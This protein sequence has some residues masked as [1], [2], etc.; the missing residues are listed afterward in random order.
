MKKLKLIMVAFALLLGVSNASAGTDVTASY[1]GDVTW[2]VNG[3]GWHGS[4]SNN[5]KESNGIG[6]YNSQTISGSHAFANPSG[7]NPGESWSPNFGTAGIMMGRTMV[8]PE[9]NYTL[10][11]E[12]FGCNADNSADPTTLP[13]AGDAV[14][15]LTGKDNVDIT[16]TAAAGDA[17]FHNVSFTFDVTTAN[18]AFEFGIKKLTDGSKIDWCQIKNVS[19]VLNS[20]DKFPVANNTVDAFTYSLADAGEKDTWHTNTWSTEGQGDGSRFQVPFHELWKASGGKLLDA[21]IT[22]S[23]TPTEDGVY[24]VSAWVR[25]ANESGGAVNGVNIFVG[26]TE[27]NACSGS[28]S[29]MSGKGRLGTFT[30]MADG[31]AGTPFNFGFKIKDSDANWLS[32]KNVTITYLGDLPQDEIDALLAQVPSGKMSSTIQSTLTSRVN[33]LNTYKSVAAY[34]ALTSYIATANASIIDYAN[35]S[36]AIAEASS[37]T[38]LTDV[39]TYSAAIAAAQDVYDD[40]SVEDCSTTINS[41][42]TAKQT[43]NVT[44]YTYVTEEFP[45]AVSLGTWTTVNAGEMRGQHWDGTTDDKE[46]TPYNEQKEGWGSGNWTCSYSQDLALPA[47]NYVFKVAGRRSV[48]ATLTLTV[49]KGASVLGTVNDFPIGDTG[50]GITTAGVASFGEG[51]F[52]NGGT[53]RG[54]QWRY[55]KFTLADPATVNVAVA[56]A[57]TPIYN[58]VGFCNAT[59]QTDEEDNVAIMTALVALNDAKAAATLTKRTANVGTGVFQ[60]SETE[61]ESLWGAYS[62]AKDDADAFEITSSSTVSDVTTVT[63]AL[64]S[65]QTAYSNFLANPT[66][67]A[68]DPSKRYWVTMH[69]DG[70]AWDGFAIT[71]IAGGRTGEGDYNVQYLATSNANMNQA[72]K[73]TQVEGNTYKISGIRVADGT[74]Q[75]LTGKLKGY[76]SGNNDQIRTIND[77]SKALVITVQATTTDNQ[78]KLINETGTEI[79]R[80][81]ET[82]DNGVYAAGDVSSYFTIQEASQASVTIDIPVAQQYATAI[83]PFT[84]S[85][86]SG[87][88]AYSCAAAPGNV[89]TLVEVAEPAANTP[90]ILE[91]TSGYSGD[92]LQG[93]GSASA[94]TYTEGWLTGVYT[95]TLAPNGSYVLAK[96]NEKVAFY[97]FEDD[98]NP[99]V[100]ANRCYLTAT[101]PARALYF[102]GNEGTGIEAVNALTSGDAKIF[103]ASGAQI[104][105]LQKGMNIVKQSNGKSYKVIVK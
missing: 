9:G 2:I 13:S 19:L 30:A 16:N 65:A 40:A 24:K 27:A 69:D 91:A 3:G 7:S 74:E 25:V 23:H 15:F 42:K 8:L 75:Y 61:N 97:N 48:D 38:P 79:S 18:T 50:K 78:F 89:L 17:T 70:Q 77:A 35:L 76:E 46:G 64:T 31:T 12:A 90:Y 66:L 105:A 56:G 82:P 11:F 71:F 103:N 73:F 52:A 99:T 63:S 96:I 32:F 5:H 53:G 14:A 47:G 98:D 68:P 1:I 34:N 58:W 67:N 94:S 81:S 86:P 88:K 95:D 60:V 87:V 10:S 29:V 92:A 36:D 49:T 6:W 104:P 93:W 26:D 55:V 51:E 33:D 83:F 85:L 43:A 84:P 100:R 20:T 41:L 54:W 72:L 28:T 102:P 57:A 101:A 45:Y 62:D 39:A 59:V 22:A 44:D 21:D 80:N 4:C 37:Y